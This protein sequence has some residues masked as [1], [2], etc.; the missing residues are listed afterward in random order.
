MQT[1]APITLKLMNSCRITRRW[2][3]ADS[4]VSESVKYMRLA[5]VMD[6]NMAKFLTLTEL[7]TWMGR[8]ELIEIYR[9]QKVLQ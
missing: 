5:E 4:L 9:N 1:R 7:P 8:V 3:K 2:R 6:G